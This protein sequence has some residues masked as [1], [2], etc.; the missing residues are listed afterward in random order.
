MYEVDRDLEIPAF[1]KKADMEKFEA[2]IKN[3][4]PKLQ[5]TLRNRLRDTHL[6][7]VETEAMRSYRGML[8]GYVSPRD[9]IDIYG[10]EEHEAWLIE[11]ERMED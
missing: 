2:S 8:V 10:T 3:L 11:M 9:P 5:E 6:E 4:H 1:T 7:I